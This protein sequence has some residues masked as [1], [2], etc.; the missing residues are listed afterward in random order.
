MSLCED[1]LIEAVLRIKRASEEPLTA[2]QVHAAL[3]AE[4]VTCE[5]KE[6]K[7]AASKAAKRAPP[8][9]T[10]AT[11]SEPPK[12]Q[13]PS[14]QS[15]KKEAAM[16]TALKSAEM[17]MQ[18]AQ[19]AYHEESWMVALH[20]NTEET[21][22][23]IDRA[24][25]CAISGLLFDGE[26]VCKERVEADIATLHYMLLPGSPFNLPE[27][28][29]NAATTQL[30]LLEKTKEVGKVA[31][32]NG[33]PFVAQPTFQSNRQGFAFKTGDN[34]LGY[35]HE[36]WFAAASK[37]YA[38]ASASATGA[39]AEE[40]EPPPTD[41]ALREILVQMREDAGSKKSAASTHSGFSVDR[42]IAKAT[43]LSLAAADGTLEDID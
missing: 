24:A 7:K 13:A 15:L 4:N 14:K 32:P 41:P 36:A 22:A 9:T 6:V 39:E 19:K 31:S 10:A 29:R 28:S 18:W 25:A 26:I 21:K 30:A 12:P 16:A 42:A 23:F 35:Y 37:C 38:S 11:E 33:A 34:G 2:A 20:G 17:A 27:E 5:L 3:A 40:E 43:S 1:E 8:T